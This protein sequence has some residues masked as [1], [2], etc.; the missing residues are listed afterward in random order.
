MHIIKLLLDWTK[1]ENRNYTEK[2]FNEAYL[3]SC[4]KG[5]YEENDI[6][7]ILDGIIPYFS[8]IQDQN[9]FRSLCFI[10]L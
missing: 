5:V 10:I 6:N 3:K 7:V 2:I 8:I 1:A 9:A 4:G